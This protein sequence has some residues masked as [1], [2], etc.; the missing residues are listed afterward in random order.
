M[1]K[2]II[3]GGGMAG[4]SAGIYLQKNGFATEIFEMYARPGG[5]CTAW[6]RKD[7]K[8]DGCIHWLV[9]VNPKSS[10]YKIWNDLIDIK[11]LPTVTYDEFCTLEDE[12]GIIHYYG[13]IGKLEAEMLRIAPEDEAEIRELTA[14]MRKM[15]AKYG[16]I[17]QPVTFADKIKFIFKI[18]PLMSMFKKYSI[19]LGEYAKRFK[20]ERLRNF[21]GTVFWSGS[22]VI[23]F[24]MNTSWFN[25]RDAGYPEGGA[26][27]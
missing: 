4:L 22:P 16:A 17:V 18:M 13:D 25:A 19:T 21:L 9:G 14:A 12:Q 10:L 11:T 8:I 5:L 7:Y 15:A 2:V 6:Q 23:V 27:K 24:L 26:M 3:I 1:K 20:S